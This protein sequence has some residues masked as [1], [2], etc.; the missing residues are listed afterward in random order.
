[1]FDDATIVVYQAYSPAIA[2]AA[3]TAGT[4]VAPFKR[5]RMTWVKPSFLW[6]MYRC[7]WATKPGQE[8]V[9][10][11]RLSRAGFEE[12]LAAACLSHFDRA[13][14]TTTPRRGKRVSGR[15]RCASSGTRSARRRVNRCRTA[16]CRSGSEVGL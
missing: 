13:V 8:R 14:F 3:L 7:G 6:M 15:R 12:A 10:A 4:F 9:L 1:M 2:D 5:D 11:V 16:R